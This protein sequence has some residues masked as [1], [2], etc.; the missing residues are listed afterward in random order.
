[1]PVPPP[2]PPP[3]PPPQPGAPPL[4]SSFAVHEELPKHHKDEAQG[5]SALLED[6]RKGKRLKKVTQVND[7]SAPIVDKPKGRN[8]TETGDGAAL[9]T[10]MG[11]LFQGG[12]PVLRPTGQRDTSERVSK[13]ALPRVGMKTQAPRYLVQNNSGRND[14]STSNQSNCPEPTEVSKVQRALQGRLNVSA[15]A[16]PP[17]PLT[18]PSPGKSPLLCPS[19][20]P[21]QSFNKPTK[22]TSQGPPP[23]PPPPQSVKPSKFQYIQPP[24]SPPLPPPPPSHNFQDQTSD[25]LFPAPPP[26]LFCTDD[27]TEFPPPPPP[28]PPSP[29]SIPH[30]KAESP[31]PPPPPPPLLSN[32]E[33]PPPLPPKLPNF[34]NRPSTN[35]MSPLPPQLPSILPYGHPASSSGQTSYTTQLPA[36]EAPSRSGVHNGG[37][38]LASPP[39]PP[40]RSS[41]TEV[42]SRNQHS[43]SS[44]RTPTQTPSMLPP[45]PPPPPPLPLK[46]RQGLASA[47]PPVYVDDFESKYNFHS[48]EDLPPPDEYKS[49]PRTYPSKQPRASQKGHRTT[50]LSR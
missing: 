2:P 1:M 39:L 44:I 16:P 36:R 32:P 21:A 15:L 37:G 48:V 46:N 17:L 11:G 7:R 25:F 20:I 27:C 30:G 33:V 31:L 26:P 9:P 45:P 14:R 49:F 28:L 43:P 41:S 6:I 5:K 12:F 40:F 19:P 4:P 22:P 29:S 23:P 24:P 18:P 47:Q 38:K 34:S 35:P 42:T 3:P 10:A 50:T 13:P 8:G